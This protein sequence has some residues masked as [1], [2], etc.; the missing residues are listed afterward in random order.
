MAEKP[1]IFVKIDDIAK[2]AQSTLERALLPLPQSLIRQTGGLISHCLRHHLSGNDAHP[3]L[4]K[5]AKMGKCS[6]RQ[7]Q[8][9]LR[10]LEAWG[11]MAP[12]AYLKG[13]RR[14]TRYWLDLDA[15]KRAMVTMGCNPS[16]VFCAKISD[17]N[18]DMRGDM[19][20][21]TEGRHMSCHDVTRYT[22]RDGNLG[23]GDRDE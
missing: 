17:I 6:H 1:L 11:V 3:G 22:Y 14:A 18:H 20:G 10:C 12:T 19:R 5:M 7:A 2:H 8:R 13:G 4:A 15:L 21:D 9:N 16:G 23:I